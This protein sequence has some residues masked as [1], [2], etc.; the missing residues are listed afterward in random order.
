MDLKT[1][2]ISWQE[3][4]SCGTLS[5]LQIRLLSLCILGK[6]RK[7]HAGGVFFVAFV[8]FFRLCFRNFFFQYWLVFSLF[9]GYFEITVSS[10]FCLKYGWL[11]Y[12]PF[13]ALNILL[14]F[15]PLNFLQ[16]IFEFK[17]CCFPPQ[18]LKILS[19]YV[20]RRLKFRGFRS[21][22]ICTIGTLPVHFLYRNTVQLFLP[23]QILVCLLFR[24]ELKLVC[25]FL[26]GR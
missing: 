6:I 11:K 2:Y 18:F 21:T 15:F 16:N 22:A 26:P 9:F 4:L 17:Y 7:S 19:K 25:L 12:C 23:E 1:F 24:M 20:D 13:F 5:I 14:F 8:C 3:R 10:N